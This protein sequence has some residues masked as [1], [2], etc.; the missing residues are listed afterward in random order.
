MALNVSGGRRSEGVG[1]GPAMIALLLITSIAGVVIWLAVRADDTASRILTSVPRVTV[2]VAPAPVTPQR[3]PSAS[4]GPTNTPSDGA[5]GTAAPGASPPPETTS[6]RL[7]PGLVQAPASGVFEETEYGVLPKIA[8]DGRT[9]WQTYARPFNWSDTRPRV[10]FVLTDVGMSTSKTQTVIDKLPPAVTFAIDPAS[11]N[12]QQWVDRARRE[13]H[14]VLL[15]VPMEPIGYPRID[16]GPNTL[17]T[18]LHDD[19]NSKRLLY[20]YGRM[21]GFVGITTTSGSRFTSVQDSMNTVID[22][23]RQRGLLLVDSR[24]SDRSVAAALATRGNVPRAIVDEKVDEIPVPN[25]IDERLSILESTAKR[26]G[27]ALGFGSITYPVTIERVAAWAST[28]EQRGVI[29]API[30]AI[31]NRQPDR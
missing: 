25:L 13:G 10:A 29:L 22:S 7:T 11:N 15:S 26:T 1:R 18:L 24:V 3:P 4:S 14:E 31:V 23:L 21:T 30:T 16:P 6:G 17:L 5:P 2:A 28:L 19:E 27:T 20:S 9:P 8:V 12:I